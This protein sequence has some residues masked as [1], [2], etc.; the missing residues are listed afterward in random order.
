M[1]FK[2]SNYNKNTLSIT[3]NYKFLNQI[4]IYFKIKYL[5]EIYKRYLKS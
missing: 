3:N 4:L 2:F 1:I 5:K